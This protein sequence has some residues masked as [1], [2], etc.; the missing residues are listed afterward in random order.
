MNWPRVGVGC[1]QLGGETRFGGRETGWGPLDD[2]T[3]AAILERCLALGLRLFDTADAYGRGCAET[4]LGRALQRVD[5]ALVITK[6]GQRE[7]DGRGTVDFSEAWLMQAVE[8]SLARL[9][10]RR[11]DVL[12]LHSPPD[13][14][15]Y[16]GHDRRALDRLVA[17]GVVGCWGVSVRSRH[18]AERALRAGF[19][20]AIELIYNAFDRRVVDQ[21]FPLAAAR[22]VRL[23]ARCPLGSGFLAGSGRR[24]LPATDVRSSLP[25]EQR[26]WLVEHGARFLQALPHPDGPAVTALRY[27]LSDPRIATVV[28]GVR[29]PA[30][31]DALAR[32]V[33]LGPLPRADAQA[34]EHA[35]PAPC[36]AWP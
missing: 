4:R 19:G 2:A 3:A 28:A 29:E 35:L 7:V 34:I 14:Y 16:A 25:P 32:A 13:D 30:Q 12:L 1:W 33:A 31:A 27:V 9:G 6:F 21:V 15:D 36:P 18:G 24:T 11:L 20:E 10:R 8:G 22:G 23:I 17:E 26:A 5:D